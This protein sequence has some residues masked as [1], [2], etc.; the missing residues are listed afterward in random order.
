MELLRVESLDRM[1]LVMRRSI[2]A[3]GD[4]LVLFTVSARVPHSP[5][6]VVHW[7]LGDG[8]KPPLDISIDAVSRR[9]VEVAFFASHE[10][11]AMGAS[12]SALPPECEGHIVFDTSLWP[13]WQ[14]GNRYVDMPGKVRMHLI[15]AGLQVSFS[16][17]GAAAS[18]GGSKLAFLVNIGEYVCGLVLPELGADELTVLRD[19]HVLPPESPM[20]TGSPRPS[21][22]TTNLAELQQRGT[23]R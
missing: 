12:A 3:I 11:I 2:V 7:S 23:P 18:I 8:S 6:D 16:E 1:P 10:K 15:N 19:A 20:P 14:R 13:E 22:T 5:G 21:G 17:T 9:F 4:E